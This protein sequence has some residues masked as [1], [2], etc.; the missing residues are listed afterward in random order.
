MPGIC[1][2]PLLRSSEAVALAHH[3][4]AHGVDEPQHALAL[5]VPLAQ[6]LEEVLDRE[7][8]DLLVEAVEALLRLALERAHPQQRVLDRRL[9]LLAGAA[10]DLLLLLLGQRREELVGSGLAVDDRRGDDPAGCHLERELQL[11]GPLLKRLEDL[12]AAQLLRLNRFGA[13][14]HIRVRVEGL[15]NLLAGALYRPLHRLC[16]F[17]AL[18][19]VERDPTG[20]SGS[21]K[22][23]TYTQSG[24]GGNDSARR[25]RNDSRIED[26][27]MPSGPEA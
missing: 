13:L 24:G 19:G 7:L 2:P 15:L 5:P 14:P 26:L 21:S 4:G 3:V 6:R 23:W 10:L 18:A 25:R 12:R 1:G 20:R 9:E 8:G 27:P 22:L 17:T 16:E 11:L